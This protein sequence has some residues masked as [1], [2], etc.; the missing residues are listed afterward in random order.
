MTPEEFKL[1]RMK[2]G[3]ATPTDFGEL[4]GVSH[5]AVY[6]KENDVNQ[7]KNTLK[8]LMLFMSQSNSRTINKYANYMIDENEFYLIRVKFGRTP[9]IFANRVGMSFRV[10]YKYESGFEIPKQISMLMQFL[11]RSTAKQRE[12]V[13]WIS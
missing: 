11:K 1:I 3:Y 10:I 9:E 5:T 7:I 4:L 13:G 12:K 2:L 6:S 8:M